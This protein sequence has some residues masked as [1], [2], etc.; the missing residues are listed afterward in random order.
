VIDVSE[1][2]EVKQIIKND[3]DFSAWLKTEPDIAKKLK[4]NPSEVHAI[5][6]SWKK[7]RN[8]SMSLQKVKD[9]YE[10]MSQQVQELNVLL[11]RLDY[12]ANSMKSINQQVKSS[13]D[14]NLKPNSVPISAKK[15]KKKR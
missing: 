15:T 7:K 10:K 6:S 2:K 9:N 5:Y 8:Q 3:P 1:K 12:L 13:N 11:K 4:K 14:N